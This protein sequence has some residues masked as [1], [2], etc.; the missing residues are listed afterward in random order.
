MRFSKVENSTSWCFTEEVGPKV[1][2]DAPSIEVGGMVFQK[3]RLEA[4]KIA[5]RS[6]RHG[7][8]QRK[9]NRKFP[10][11][12]IEAGGMMFEKVRPEAPKNA[13]RSLRHGVSQRKLYRKFQKMQVRA[14]SIV[15][16]RK[17]F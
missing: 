17:E 16:P 3:V 10:K 5:Y 8:S 15:F 1:P 4:P 12:P 14:G 6:R 7:V 9:L 11:C 2:K 13:Y